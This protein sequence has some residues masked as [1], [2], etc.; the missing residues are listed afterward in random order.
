MAVHIRLKRTGTK[1][2]P[3]YRIVVAD[4]R[5]PRNG[6]SLEEIG[7]YDPKRAG[8]NFLVDCDRAK[9]WLARG[10]QPT[11]TVRDILKKAQR[12]AKAA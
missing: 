5:T 10:A 9:H 8:E 12:K 4:S 11:L 1:N 3:S 2:L 6:R 7:W